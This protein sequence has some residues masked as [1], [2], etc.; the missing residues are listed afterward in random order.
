M[1]LYFERKI[2]TTKKSFK[3]IIYFFFKGKGKE[4]KGIVQT[5]PLLTDLSISLHNT[6]NEYVGKARYDWKK[7]KNN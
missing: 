6:E 3:D 5:A 7:D 2:A 1:S 4:K